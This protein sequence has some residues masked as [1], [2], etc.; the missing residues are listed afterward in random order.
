M[1][2]ALPAGIS[3]ARH[4]TSPSPTTAASATPGSRGCTPYNCDATYCPSAHAAGAPPVT[5]DAATQAKEHYKRGTTL[6]D[7]NRYEEAIKEFRK[8][9][10]ADNAINNTSLILMI[11][12]GA[13]HL[14]F[15]GDAQWGPWQLL[16]DNAEAS[17]MLAKTTFYKVG[18]HG[19]HNATPKRFVEMWAKSGRKRTARQS[20]MSVTR[21]SFGTGTAS[22][23]S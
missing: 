15:P 18:H 12:V 6:Y 3:P 20:M 1:R 23:I 10:S 16:L 8:A 4:D 13:A 21:S 9:A 7:L 5:G 11:R 22:S 19:S 2:L 17:G 14:L